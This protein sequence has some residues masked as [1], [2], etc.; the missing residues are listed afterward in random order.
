MAVPPLGTVL[1]DLEQ[2]RAD[3]VL[4]VEP[5]ERDMRVEGRAPFEA[6]V[7]EQLHLEER[8]GQAGEVIAVD[9]G[10]DESGGHIELA[11]IVLDR[12]FG[13]PLRGRGPIPVH[14]VIGHAA[15]DVVLDCAGALGGVCEIAADSDLVAG[16]GGGV[17]E[18]QLGALEELVH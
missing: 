6:S 14:G 5:G 9:T 11:D 4:D 8:V 1:E 16:L 7:R 15:V 10:V 2:G 17:N 13:R 3:V 18:G 12:E